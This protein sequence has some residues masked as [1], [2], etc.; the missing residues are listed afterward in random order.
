MVDFLKRN[1]VFV[2]VVVATLILLLGG[3]Y[4]FSKNPQES[5]TAKEV[6][7][8]LLVHEGVVTTSGIQNGEY[9][10]ASESAKVSIVEFGDYQCPACASYYPFIKQLLTELPG[11]INYTFRNFPLNQHKNAIPAAYA[12]EAAGLQN[13]YWQMH[14]KV[15]ETYESWANLENAAPFFEELA[16]GLGLNPDQYKKDVVSDKVKDIVKRD[17]QDGYVV[18]ISYT[19]TF[20]LNN[21][22]LTTPQTY[23][24][25][26]KVVE[27]AIAK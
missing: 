12:V 8:E 1:I 18:K 24:Q 20:F 21:S 2:S 17:T 27:D 5:A 3:V 26:K 16:A 13:K 22:L 11:R 19:P 10:P 15:Y 9:L 25:L 6:N 23:E 4:L 14:A 7:P